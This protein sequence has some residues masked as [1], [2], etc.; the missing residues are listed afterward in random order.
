MMLMLVSSV[1]RLFIFRILPIAD[2]THRPH[3][4]RDPHHP[5]PHHHRQSLPAP[6]PPKACH[7]ASIFDCRRCFI[8]RTSISS[9]IFAFITSGSRSRYQ[10]SRGGCNCFMPRCV[11]FSARLNQ[12]ACSSGIPAIMQRC[13]HRA[14][15][16]GLVNSLPRPT[17]S[18]LH[19][20]QCERSGS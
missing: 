7:L 15:V 19:S 4:V 10:L 16:F 13:G 17:S 6:R 1:L 11:G 8:C 14:R 2:L 3:C 12:L 5:Q 18:W 20:P 9:V